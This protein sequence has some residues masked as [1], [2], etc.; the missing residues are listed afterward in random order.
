[1]TEESLSTSITV[2][3]SSTD[4]SSD[5]SVSFWKPSRSAVWKHFCH[6]KQS[7]W[8][9][10]YKK[11]LSYNV[12]TTCSLIQHL[13]KKRQSQVAVQKVKAAEDTIQKQ[14]SIMQFRKLEKG[15][16]INKLCSVETQEDITCILTKWT[17]KEMRPISIVRDKGLNESLVFLEPNYKPPSITH[18]SAWIYK[19]FE[20]RK[21]AVKQQLHGSQS[22]HW[23]RYF[24]SHTVFC[25]YSCTLP[26]SAKRI[27]IPNYTPPIV[28]EL[29]HSSGGTY[30][31]VWENTYWGILKKTCFGLLINSFGLLVK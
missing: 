27:W 18:V 3:V 19:D 24:Q 29:D 26:W 22:H 23:Y 14:L 9:L 6:Y 13:K 31:C 15:K 1:M 30:W 12:R 5:A 10:L 20:D 2:T 8:C 17:W 25:N 16:S 21:A 11:V 28:C 4:I 7:M